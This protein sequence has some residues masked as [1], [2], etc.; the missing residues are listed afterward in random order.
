MGTVWT[1]KFWFLI[2]GQLII[3]VSA[4]LC[5]NV[6]SKTSNAWFGEKERTTATAIMILANPFGVVAAFVIQGYYSGKGYFPK[7]VVA[8]EEL[9]IH[10]TNKIIIC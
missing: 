5:H 7:E 10:G 6:I 4:P 3:Y 9:V 8:G 2:V 1:G